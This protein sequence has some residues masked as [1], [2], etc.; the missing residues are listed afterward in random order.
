MIPA[1]EPRVNN[2]PRSKS[3]SK[4]KQMTVTQPYTGHAKPEVTCTDDVRVMS[5]KGTRHHR[6]RAREAFGGKQGTLITKCRRG[7]EH[8]IF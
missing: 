2:P 8:I 4:S 7:P 1:P 6:P 3:W 5:S